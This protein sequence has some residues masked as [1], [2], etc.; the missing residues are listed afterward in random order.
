MATIDWPDTLALMLASE[1]DMKEEGLILYI[2]GN[3]TLPAKADGQALDYES[4][5]ATSDGWATMGADTVVSVASNELV[6]TAGASPTT[7]VRANKAYVATN[8]LIEIKWRCA[9][10]DLTTLEIGT[11]GAGTHVT[12]NIAGFTSGTTVL[13]PGANFTDIELIFNSTGTNTNP[14]YIE[15][16]YSWT[17]SGGYYSEDYGANN[18]SGSSTNLIPMLVDT[19][20][21][22]SGNALQFHGSDYSRLA[23]TA[24]FTCPQIFSFAFSIYAPVINALVNRFAIQIANR[25]TVHIT[26]SF[27]ASMQIYLYCGGIAR[28][29][30]GNY[31]V[32]AATW[33][34]W[35][36]TWDGTTV[37]WYRGGALL[38]SYAPGFGAMDAS[39]GTDTILIG[40][41]H[42]G[43]LDEIK[44]WNRVLTTSEVYEDFL[45]NGNSYEA[46][47]TYPLVDGWSEQQQD[48]VLRSE[49]DAGTAKIRRRFTAAST[50]MNCR[51]A[52]T[53]FQKQELD[54]FWRDTAKRGSLAFN[55]THP[56]TY[57]A[58]ECR[59]LAPP[60]YVP[61][62]Q[63]VIATVPLEIL[64]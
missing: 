56:Q 7:F 26:R 30:Y 15:F 38:W 11:S 61:N 58:I 18:Y 36:V 8:M 23:T 50:F 32:T 6:L 42:D 47:P 40:A 4:N 49:V 1:Y 12:R 21:G 16:V 53:N 63:E 25:F 10:T 24:S 62:E 19:A 59:F 28:G 55:W 9:Q 35:M 14:V 20:S 64:P 57:E 54:Q 27:T 48:S 33:E 13:S 5:F 46:L 44:L 22:V 43:R 41:N 37:R 31:S 29:P 45:R 34:R 17:S 39:S 60:S 52:L 3:G 2:P 51:F